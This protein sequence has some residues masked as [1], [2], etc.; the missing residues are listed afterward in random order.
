MTM[1]MSRSEPEGA[2]FLVTVTPASFI[3]QSYS[4]HV[5][6]PVFPSSN[7]SFPSP[8]QMQSVSPLQNH[9][10]S[11]LPPLPV[12]PSLSPSLGPGPLHH[13]ATLQPHACFPFCPTAPSPVGQRPPAP[14]QC[15]AGQRRST[16]DSPFALFLAYQAAEQLEFDVAAKKKK[17]VL[18]IDEKCI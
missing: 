3:P 13:Q 8:C 18:R 5:P 16:A 9:L 7:L 17:S 10:P 12:H 11:P 14:H 15:A 6:S 1:L 2:F 4:P